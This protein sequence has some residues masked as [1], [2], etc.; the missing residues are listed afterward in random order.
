MTGPIPRSVRSSFHSCHAGHDSLISA[1][2]TSARSTLGTST[3]GLLKSSGRPASSSQ[4]AVGETV[5]DRKVTATRS[6]AVNLLVASARVPELSQ[7]S[8]RAP[9]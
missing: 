1:G 3:R 5:T 9:V 2:S 8:K 6:S 7:T 4:A